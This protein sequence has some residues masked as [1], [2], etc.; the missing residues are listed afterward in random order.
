MIDR[1][2]AK[3]INNEKKTDFINYSADSIKKILRNLDTPQNSFSSI[4]IAGTNGKGSTALYLEKIFINAGYKTGLFSSPHLVRV[5]ERIRVNSSDIDDETLINYLYKIDNLINSD[6]SAATY[7]DILTAAAFLHF[8]DSGVDIAI[9][10]TG[11]GGSRDSTNEVTPLLS[12]ITDISLDHEN[13]LGSGITNITREKCGIIKKQVPVVTSNT[14]KLVQNIIHQTSLSM[15]SLCLL[16]DRDFFIEKHVQ[17]SSG[18]DYFLSYPENDIMKLPVRIKQSNIAQIRNSALA[19]IASLYLS[20]NYKNI[21]PDNIRKSISDTVLPGRFEVKG[22]YYPLIFDP[23][24]N[25]ESFECLIYNL[26]KLYSYEKFVFIV[27]FMADKN[28]DKIFKQIYRLSNN[29]IYYKLSDQRS[30]YPDNPENFFAI[31]SNT[32]ELKN[33]LTLPIFRNHIK[34]FTGSFRLY[35]VYLNYSH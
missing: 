11:L 31:V 10:E 16:P 34:V 13:I 6:S 15:D 4:H 18:I 23:A 2:L 12:I 27:S 20:S 25:Q 21:N 32:E 33:K 24:H 8:R 7:F 26:K 17:S 1:I 22:E 28:I 9:I 30:Y 3:Y 14:G 29:V 35:Q 5:N 19:F